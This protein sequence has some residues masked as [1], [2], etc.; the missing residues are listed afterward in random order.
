M[1]DIILNNEKLAFPWKTQDPFLFCAY[2]RDI[3]P[4]GNEK[5]GPEEKL[6]GRNLGNDFIVKN[7]WRMYHGKTVP[8]FPSHPH[9][10]FETITFILQGT[11]DHADSK[12]GAGRYSHRDIQWMTA[13]KGLQHS[14]M[15][16]LLNRT[17]T[18]TLELFQI[19]LNLPAQ[20][21]MTNPD[22]K[23]IWN[24]ENPRQQIPDEKGRKVEIDIIAGSYNSVSA[25]PPTPDS[26]AADPKNGVT[27]WHIIM[28]PNA[29]FSILPEA[30]VSRSL[31]FFEGE[32]IYIGD[33]EISNNK[34]LHL[35]PS[36]HTIIRN[37][38]DKSRLLML[39]GKPLEE[40]VAQYGP[41]V[42]NTMEEIHQAF[43]DYR[44]SGFG[45]WPWSGNEVVHPRD[46]GRFADYGD[47]T[48]SKP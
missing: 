9:R 31:Y 13:G 14:E 28:D 47:G 20:K 19:W 46:K 10:G 43:D 11:V 29:L 18:N 37:G 40:P 1:S 15:F 30:G 35:D 27:I 34:M 33:T 36:K 25:P 23:M 5:F 26:W 42:M 32:S 48:E 39:Q 7:G 6:E 8:G 17:G 44:A 24:E 3:Y 4:R 22:Y 16:P 21:K 2:H 45:G 38:A 41:F 12:G